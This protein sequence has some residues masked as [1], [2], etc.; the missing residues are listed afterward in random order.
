M[1]VY[2]GSVA[3]AGT[4]KPAW[5]DLWMSLS[6]FTHRF[7][8]AAPSLGKLLIVLHGRGD[9]MDGFTWLPEA[10]NLPD[11][12]Y[13]FLNAPDDY[14]GG[15][16]WY[17][18]PPQQGPGILRSRRML[19]GVLDDLV[20]R[21]WAPLDII[22]FGFSQGC[23]MALDVG[24][25]YPSRLG[26]I[27]GISG[28]VHFAETLA[29]EVVPQAREMPWWVSAGRLDDVVPFAQTEQGVLALQAVGV[30]VAFHAYE[31]GHTIDPVK[32][33]PAVR[34]WLQGSFGGAHS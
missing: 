4:I 9:S 26:G 2:T 18:L 6:N 3:K 33:L 28:Y 8:P 27:C 29:T 22:L 20:A 24:A 14:F 5:Y 25:R 30:R 13:L 10:L 16:S 7:S 11:T 23:L 19:F 12:S 31:K 32:E 17:A 21:G 34:E 1:S 15:F